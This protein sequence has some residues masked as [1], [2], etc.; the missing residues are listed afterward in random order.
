VLRAYH[1]VRAA[2]LT[3]DDASLGAFTALELYEDALRADPDNSAAAKALARMLSGDTGRL[4]DRLGEA[5]GRARATDQIVL[6]GTAIGRAALRPA[7]AGAGP[8]IGIGIDAMNRVLA[9]LPDDVSGLMLMSSLLREQQLWSEAVAALNRVVEMAGSPE[10]RIAAYFELA[11]IYEGPLDDGNAAE[12]ALQAVLGIDAKNRHALERLYQVAAARGDRT[13]AI[14]VL[15]RLAEGESDPAARAEY[16]LRLA[17][18]CREGNDKPGMIRAL[19][20]AVVSAP[21]DQRAWKLLGS[22]QRSDTVDGATAYAKSLQQVLDIASARRLPYDHRWLTTLGLLEATVLRR[23][24]DGLA[25]LQQAV[26]LPGAPPET[27]VALGRGLEAVGRNAES[28]QVLRDVLALDAD[29]IN[30]IVDVSAALTALESAL[31]KDGRA[32]ERL[33]VEEVRACLGEI[34]GERVGRLRA[35]RLPPDVPFPMALAG[36]EIARLLVPEARSPMIDVSVA[37]APIAA[38]ALRFELVNLGI[39]SRDRVGA[40]DGHPTRNLADKL[41]RSLGVEA[42]ELYLSP[43]WQGAARVYPGD[44]PAIV[45]PASFAELPEPEQCFALARL[46]TRIALGLTWLDELTVEAVDGLLLAAVRMIDPQ[47]GVGEI[48]PPREAHVQGF[49]GPVAKAFGRRQRKLLEEIAPTVSA[50]YDARAFTIGVRRSEYRAAYALS[51]DLVSAVDY[52]RRFDREIS[53]ST[54][55]PRVLLAHP[56]TNELIRFALTAEAYAE[57]RRLGT[58]WMGG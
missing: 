11:T 39:S 34:K 50:S 29:T 43:T 56:V 22:L 18:A 55:E 54:D 4:A 8:E 40:R 7:P 1:L 37:L 27:R 23:P 58:V 10:Q 32:E 47:F 53:R 49:M 6:L 5:L 14:S 31:A 35:R 51:G 57:R 3:G 2:E 12:G 28:V 24:M 21:N 42:F 16:D 46:V 13:L 9:E 33:A 45:G 15:G 52:L 36:S 26:A 25:H 20:D 17:E 30:R 38:K 41:A 48:T 44:P 19:C